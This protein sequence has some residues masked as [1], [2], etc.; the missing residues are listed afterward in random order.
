[1]RLKLLSTIAQL[2]EQSRAQLVAAAASE[3]HLTE[4]RLNNELNRTIF[5]LETY[6][7]ASQKGYCLEASLD[8]DPRPSQQ[9]LIFEKS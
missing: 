8:H 5:Q 3:S 1:M 6:G 9:N 2:I 4:T 7:A